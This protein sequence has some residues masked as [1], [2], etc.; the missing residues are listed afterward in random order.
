LAL[1]FGKIPLLDGDP[2]GGLRFLALILLSY[3]SLVCF[4]AA[5]FGNLLL[6]FSEAALLLSSIAR[7]YSHNGLY[8]GHRKHQP[9]ERQGNREL[10]VP[11][12][13]PLEV[14]EYGTLFALAN[15]ADDPLTNPWRK[16]HVRTFCGCGIV[17]V[18]IDPV[19]TRPL[20]SNQLGQPAI[21]FAC[22]VDYD[23]SCIA[24]TAPP[25]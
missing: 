7:P 16:I 8:H 19:N 12:L 14:L 18:E 10:F 20:I 3:T 23:G 9:C 25:T 2:F 15:S 4:N 1:L 5:L 22:S 13:G 21:S 11:P 24:M 17:Y 6:A